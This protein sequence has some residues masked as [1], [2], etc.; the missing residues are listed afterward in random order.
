MYCVPLAGGLVI[1]K[2]RVIKCWDEGI[3]KMGGQKGETEWEGCGK[4]SQSGDHG[5]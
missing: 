4:S 2:W 3:P 1:G 5:S